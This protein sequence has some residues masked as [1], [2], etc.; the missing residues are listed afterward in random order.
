MSPKN[1][2]EL[3]SVLTSTETSI[4]RSK[5]LKDKRLPEDYDQISTYVNSTCCKNNLSKMVVPILTYASLS[6]LKQNITDERKLDKLHS[7]ATCVI[8]CKRNLPQSITDERK[9]D[10]LH[11]RATCVISCKRNLPQSICGMA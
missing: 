3:S 7:R 11:S 1:I 2:L 8:S 4:F 9:L 5:R 6:T 10:K